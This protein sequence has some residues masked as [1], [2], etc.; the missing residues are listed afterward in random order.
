MLDDPEK[1]PIFQA[2]SNKIKQIQDDLNW[3]IDPNDVALVKGIG[4]GPRSI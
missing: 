1:Q 2:I 4:T 3:E